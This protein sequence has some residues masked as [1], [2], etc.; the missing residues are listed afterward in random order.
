MAYNSAFYD[1]EFWDLYDDDI[2]PFVKLVYSNPE[3]NKHW[4]PLLNP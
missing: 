2:G 3:L 4:E 1:N